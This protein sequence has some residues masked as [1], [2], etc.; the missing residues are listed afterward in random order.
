MPIGLRPF[1]L[2][3]SPQGVQLESPQ[4]VI[5]ITSS[6]RVHGG[7]GSGGSRNFF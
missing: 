1:G 7:V 3:M 4:G 6:I 5:S 2:N